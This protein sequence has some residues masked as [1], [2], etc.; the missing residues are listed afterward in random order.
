MEKK[1]FVA[2]VLSVTALFTGGCATG[3]APMFTTEIPDYSSLFP[4][5]SN[6]YTVYK[7]G[8]PASE[9]EAL[10]V[11]RSSMG[12][13]I[14][15]G[16]KPYDIYADKYSAVF[17]IQ[18]TEHSTTYET[19]PTYGGFFWGWD[20]IPT[21]SNTTQTYHQSEQKNDSLTIQ[22]RDITGMY[23]YKNSL[24][25]MHPGGASDISAAN[26]GS[27][28]TL[29]DAIY[30]LALKNGARVEEP[31]FNSQTLTAKQCELLKIEAGEMV[32]AVFSGSEADAAGLK[33]GDVILNMDE[34]KSA[35]GFNNFFAAKKYLKI[36]R[37]SMKGSVIKY[38]H[39]R[40]SMKEGK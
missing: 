32:T 25:M 21:Y 18:W 3:G 34:V 31:L 28:K 1:V 2:V 8:R 5:V 23:F 4:P 37:W 17:K 12:Y 10:S 11:I 33:A 26:P 30:T 36:L 40:I 27:L 22:F 29:A 13:A 9:D 24:V 20:Y 6:D 35:K 16:Q 19:T 14:I 7:P 15:R 38:K 39:V